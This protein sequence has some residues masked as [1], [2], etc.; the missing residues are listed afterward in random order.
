M[1]GL[2]GYWGY[3]RVAQPLLHDEDRLP[4]W[5]QASKL[6]QLLL[7]CLLLLWPYRLL[8]HS[9]TC[10]SSIMQFSESLKRK[11]VFSELRWVVRFHFPSPHNLFLAKAT[12]MAYHVLEEGSQNSSEDCFILPCL[13]NPVM[14]RCTHARWQGII[15]PGVPGLL[16]ETIMQN[17]CLLLNAGGMRD[18]LITAQMCL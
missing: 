4:C 13:V 18:L 9:S 8:S 1:F 3:S 16:C 2:K 14:I 6:M 7:F 17:F 12:T 10:E 5:K 11:K 15:Q